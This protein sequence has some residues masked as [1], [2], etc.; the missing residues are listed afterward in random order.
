M[1]KEVEY[2]MAYMFA[3]SM[4]EKTHAH[5]RMTDDVPDDIK[6][7][8]LEELISVFKA[9]QLKKQKQEIGKLHH[10]MI[11]KYGARG[12]HQLSGLTDTNKR[13]VLPVRPDINIGDF[14]A[15]KVVDATY[16]TLFGEV[17][18]VKIG[19]SDFN[20]KYK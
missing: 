4:R 16:N 17:E 1:V 11:D 20:S 13:I 3:Y 2:D 5:R 8:R 10:V 6:Q 7:K 15:A 14:I 18:A 9:I 19:V 12:D